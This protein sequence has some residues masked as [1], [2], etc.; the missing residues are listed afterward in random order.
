MALEMIVA[1]GERLDLVLPEEM[2]FANTTPRLLAAAIEVATNA[3]AVENAHE[4][5][6]HPTPRDPGVEP[7]FSAGELALLFQHLDDP[8]DPRYNICR[9]YEL[10]ESTLSATGLDSAGSGVDD[11][12]FDTARFVAAL[13]TVV[14]R[15]V[16]L[17]WSFGFPRRRLGVDEA[18][19]LTI[20]S[21]AAPMVAI[22]AEAIALQSRPFDLEHG[23]LVRCRLQ[24][25][26][27]ADGEPSGSWSIALVFHHI[28]IDA[29]SFDLFWSELDAAYRGESLPELAI[30]YAD[31][32][33]WHATHDNALAQAHWRSV[34][35][36][37][38]LPAPSWP[39]TPID[40]S[41]DRESVTGASD[42]VG[43]C[44]LPGSPHRTHPFDA[45]R[46]RR[47]NAVRHRA[48]GHRHR[49]R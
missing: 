43:G 10:D 26:A 29:T 49:G 48:G 42:E 20:V 35:D 19:D 14:E 6:D 37:R 18:L 7:P 33:A 39:T 2:A 13:R 4:S 38:P 12:H 31:V 27:G 24:P 17:H 40:E 23:P 41:G 47:R 44:G 25:I 34:N 15:H 9:L 45:G 11:P 1:L 3:A 28:S 32:A 22:R 5:H 21:S 46:H 36:G 30:D 16:P 8:D